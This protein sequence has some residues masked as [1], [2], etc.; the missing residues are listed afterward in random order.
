MILLD[1]SVL[2]DLFRKQDKSKSLF[3]RLSASENEFAV[4]SITFYEI[5]IGSNASQAGFWQNFWQNLVIV[6]F[7]R[8]C[9][10]QAVQIY[11]TLKSQNQLIPLADLAIA[12]TAMAH[13]LPVASLNTKHF[14]RI[15][16]LSVIS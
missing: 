12:A 8:S 3:H 10:E 13:Q 6:P 14:Q 16:G 7:D 9:A 4:S 2:I 15:S 11:L 1:T 5:E